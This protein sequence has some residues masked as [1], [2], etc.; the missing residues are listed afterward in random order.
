MFET[1]DVEMIGPG[2]L[3]EDEKELER[4]AASLHQVGLP[5]PVD[6]PPSFARQHRSQ[7]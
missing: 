6:E 1:E 5:S 7:L 4:G 2:G 3:A